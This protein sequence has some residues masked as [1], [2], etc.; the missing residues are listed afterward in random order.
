V[1]MI[2]SEKYSK[3]AFDKSTGDFPGIFTN[4]WEQILFLPLTGITLT[5]DRLLPVIV[6]NGKPKK[7]IFIQL[8]NSPSSLHARMFNMC[9]LMNT[10]RSDYNNKGQIFNKGDILEGKLR[11]HLKL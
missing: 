5:A 9:Y 7:A 3:Y 10:G 11:I 2:I 1:G 6:L 4:N 8:Q